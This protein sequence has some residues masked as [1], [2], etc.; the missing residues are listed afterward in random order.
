M[1]L[2]AL[3]LALALLATPAAAKPLFQ[4]WI[5]GTAAAEPQT[6]TQRYDRDTYVI[7]QSVKTNFEAPFLY[8]LFG[9]D[10]A[11]L[12][13]TGAGGLK[14]RPAVD[15]A[16]DQWLGERHRQSIP[17]V[18]AHTHGHGDHRQGDPEFRD[19]PDTTVIGLTAPEVAAA[20]K[21]AD[22]PNQI[23]DFDLGGRVL[24][25]IPTPGHQPAH[26]MIYD[27][28]TRLLLT[29]DTLYPGRLYVPLNMFGDFKA[30]L[31]RVVGF[32]RTHPVKWVLGAHIEM[33]G[34]PGKDYANAAPSHPDE[35]RLELP[36]ADL[37]ALQ[38]AVRKMGDTP[39]RDV[40]PDFI[41]TPVPPR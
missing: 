34:T 13:D 41:V 22:W 12:L 27:A 36:Y 21:I 14:I 18:V 7:R 30:S 4:P 2:A 1:R 5:G 6:Q 32:T 20:F 9:R 26:I 19:R 10:R 31:D 15:A 37:L 23:V 3:G 8:L 40:H 38:A 33:T 29:G 25:V 24:K 39:A 11:L 16:I 35:H 28:R 17:L